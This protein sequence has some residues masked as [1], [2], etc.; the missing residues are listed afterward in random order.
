LLYELV[1]V[2]RKVSFQYECI[3]LVFHQR[4]IMAVM[5]PHR[6]HSDS[7]EMQSVYLV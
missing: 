7:F 4:I 6:A 1:L 5:E 3:V 2:L